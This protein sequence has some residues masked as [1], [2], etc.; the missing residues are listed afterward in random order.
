MKFHYGIYD[1]EY[2]VHASFPMMTKGTYKMGRQT[3]WQGMR[4]PVYDFVTV[5]GC[6][7]DND[8]NKWVTLAEIDTR[9]TVSSYMSAS[10]PHSARA[11]KRYVRKLI[12]R[13]SFPKGT[14]IQLSGRFVVG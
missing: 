4:I 8:T 13:Q 9:H 2:G 10:A 1:G 3:L 5:S 11:F 7:Y 12:K 14:V 6:W